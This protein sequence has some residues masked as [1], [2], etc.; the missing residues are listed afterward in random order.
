M[1]PSEVSAVLCSSWATV[2]DVSPNQRASVAALSDDELNAHLLMASE[3]LWA[4]SGRRWYGGG[5]VESATLRSAPPQPGQGTWP[6]HRT[7][8]SCGCW[9]WGGPA[10]GWVGQ[11]IASPMA[12]RLPR[13]PVTAVTAITINGL[14][15]TDYRLVRAGWLE[16]TDGRGWA[17]CDESTE[18]TYEHGEP[19]PLAG[20]AAAVEL[21]IEMG[22]AALND[23]SCRLPV[24]TT[25]VTRQGMSMT[26]VDPSEYLDKGKVGLPGVDL[27]L[28][29]VNPRATPQA[30]G[31]WSPDI[32]TTL[33]S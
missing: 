33:R 17:V 8:G 26:V 1:A 30:A 21:G 31:V 16:R 6:Y 10:N 14:P 28:A 29:A 2:D 20:L 11:H 23:N 32:P 22:K 5:C 9:A 19:P 24:R 27:W 12:V 4:L 3:I 13:S 15:F 25:Q 7:W 18:I